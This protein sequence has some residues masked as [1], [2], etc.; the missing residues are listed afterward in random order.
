MNQ[1]LTLEQT[2][3]IDGVL[4]WSGRIEAVLNQMRKNLHVIQRPIPL[5]ENSSKPIV[6]KPTKECFPV[7]TFLLD[8]VI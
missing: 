4:D 1:P 2:A 6:V 3:V 8:P 7:L 5:G